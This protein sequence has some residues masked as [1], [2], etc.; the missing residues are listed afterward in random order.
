MALTRFCTGNTSDRAVMACSLMRATKRLS[1]MLYSEFTSI[2]MTL[3]R[4]IE[5]SSGSTGL[6][7]IKVSF[8]FCFLSEGI[9]RTRPAVPPKRRKKNAAQ[10]GASA[11]HCVAKSSSEMN[12]VKIHTIF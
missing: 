4:A 1:T 10:W 12:A 2:E 7:F 6:V 5:T 8:I 9:K 3:G 11:N